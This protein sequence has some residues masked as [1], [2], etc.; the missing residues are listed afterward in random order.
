[1]RLHQLEA[2]SER[3]RDVHAIVAG[4]R[5]VRGNGDPRVAKPLEQSGEL[6]H[7]QS[8]VRLP[9]G[10]EVL[11]NSEMDPDLAALEPDTAAL[12][13][14]GRLRRLRDPEENGVEAPSFLFPTGRHRQLD[15]M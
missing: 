12:R 2:V 14:V 8:R 3:V 5:L 9:G 7:Q 13:E 6:V 11:L 10:T 4:Q 1:M 15:V